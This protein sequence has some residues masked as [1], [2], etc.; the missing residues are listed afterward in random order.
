MSTPTIAAH[1]VND[2]VKRNLIR[3]GNPALGIPEK[4][5]QDV[6]RGAHLALQAACKDLAERAGETA[7]DSVTDSRLVQSEWAAAARLDRARNFLNAI[8]WDEKSTQAAD[9]KAFDRRGGGFHDTKLSLISF[10]E[11][12]HAALKLAV[13][14]FGASVSGDDAP[15]LLELR[16]SLDSWADD[17]QTELAGERGD[18]VGA[19]SAA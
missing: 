10:F 17:A 7:R 1:E 3:A 14:H 8:G 11:E 9:P 5:V 6:Q 15:S 4:L 18:V 19:I 12:A 16:G 2:R 13:E